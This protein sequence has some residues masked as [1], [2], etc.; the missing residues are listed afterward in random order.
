MVGLFS[1]VKAAGPAAL[2]VVFLIFTI[3][4]HI[5]FRRSIGPLLDGLPRTL[6]AQEAIFQAQGE[7]AG[8][9]ESGSTNVAN[10]STAGASGEKD[11]VHGSDYGVHKK[12]NM[13]TR[14]FKPWLFADY[15][16]LRHMV[17]H[18]HD[19]NF[20]QLQASGEVV[21][22]EAY[23]P[24]SVNSAPPTLWIPEDPLGVSKHEIALTSRVIPISDKGARLDEK[25]N[26]TW[27]EDLSSE[28]NLPPVYTEKTYY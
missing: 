20:A 23:F 18:E 6:E 15:A 5:T 28:E 13:F 14:F 3:L 11:V 9:I 1:V 19:I 17:P 27:S 12:G 22:R 10:G 24:P 4:Y 25:N 21:E 26:A 16:S 8:R 7:A 2:M